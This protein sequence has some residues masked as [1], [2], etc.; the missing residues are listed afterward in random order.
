MDEQPDDAMEKQR[1][2]GSHVSEATALAENEEAHGAWTPPQETSLVPEQLLVALRDGAFGSIFE[3]LRG[4]QTQQNATL[5]TIEEVKAEL[6]ETQEQMRQAGEIFEKLQAYTQKLHVMRDNMKV[7]DENMAK[8][9]RMARGI[10][11]RL[12][13]TAEWHG[14]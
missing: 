12:E 6:N 7:L 2:E 8:T 5:Q 3:L 9:K 13:K 1:V 14:E 11:E 4:M 10:Q